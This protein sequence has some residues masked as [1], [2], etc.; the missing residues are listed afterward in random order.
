MIKIG[1]N[2][3][4]SG[5]IVKDGSDVILILMVRHLFKPYKVGT[6]K[7][8]LGDAGVFLF[9]D[10]KT[11]AGGSYGASQ[12][13]VI[14][15]LAELMGFNLEGSA[16]PIPLECSLVEIQ[17]EAT[18]Q[19]ATYVSP[20]RFWNGITRF[21]TLASTFTAKITFNIAPRFTSITAS[22]LLFVDVNKDLSTRDIIT[23]D[24]ADGIVT[25]AKLDNLGTVGTYGEVTVNS[26]GRVSSGKRIVK[27]IGTTNASGN[28]TATFSPTFSVPPNIQANIVNQASTNQFIKITSIDVNGF[29]V[30]VFQR[31]S[32]TLLGVEVLLAATT[33]VSGATVHVLVSET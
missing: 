11:L 1:L 9:S 7:I 17:N 30:N 23:N 3:N 21:L 32:V 22:K 28:Y 12:E 5:I 31:G 13:A 20:R 26:K 15:A 16:S 25:N 14:T 29:T 19:D 27:F 33:N 6:D 4:E 2:N 10:I 8:S 24:I 18:T